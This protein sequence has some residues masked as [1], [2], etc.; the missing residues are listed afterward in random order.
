MKPC[1]INAQ[2]IKEAFEYIKDPERNRQRERQAQE[3]REYFAEQSKELM[4]IY[5]LPKEEQAEQ[6]K[7][8]NAKY[9]PKLKK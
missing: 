6:L 5:K 3:A 9:Y 1:V 7:A 8:F 2:S 4:R